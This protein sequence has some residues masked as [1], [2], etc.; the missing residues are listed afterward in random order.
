MCMEGIEHNPVVYEL[1]SEM[2]LFRS[3]KVEVE[4]NITYFFYPFIISILLA[5]W[6][7]ERAAQC[8]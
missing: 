3:K 4:V 6:S 8:M 5:V 7:I 2:A 1:M